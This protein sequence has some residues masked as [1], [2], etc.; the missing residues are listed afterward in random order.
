[1]LATVDVIKSRWIVISN[2]PACYLP[3]YKWYFIKMM[4]Q[5]SILH[6][7][8]DDEE[9]EAENKDTSEREKEREA[10]NK[11]KITFNCFDDY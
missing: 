1:M 11:E 7:R 6:S 10:A 9:R 4:F 8:N 2:R 3:I 5:W